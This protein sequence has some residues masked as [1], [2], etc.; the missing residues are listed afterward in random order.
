[1]VK[2][3]LKSMIYFWGPCLQTHLHGQHYI[4]QKTELERFAR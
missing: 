2:A 1:M 4:L 3:L